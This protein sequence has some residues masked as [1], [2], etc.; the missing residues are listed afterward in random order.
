M[1]YLTFLI[2]L[3][4]AS[5]AHA[6][7]DPL[8]VVAEGVVPDQATKALILGQLHELYGAARVVDRLQV[9]SIPAPPNW[10]RHVARM[11]APGIRRVSGGKLEVDGQSVRIS[12]EVANEAQRQQVASE[13]SLASNSTYTV[14]NSLGTGAGQGLL[15]ATLGDR[16]IEFE[17]GSARL[18][19]VG[20]AI[21]DEMAGTMREIGEARVQVVGHTDNVGQRQSNIALSHARA[22]AVRDYLVEQGI[23]RRNLSVLGRGP[24]EPI[25]DNASV[26]GRARNRRIQFRLL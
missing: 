19:D 23:P 14:T 12:G 21:L 6:Q 11:L 16:I 10:G 15:D 25:A 4:A 13:L 5:A 24:D 18:T 1:R 17:S 20:R 26:D 2:A 3:L 8:P 9:E 22:D 7:S